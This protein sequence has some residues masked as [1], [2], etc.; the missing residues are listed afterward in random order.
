[1]RT[2]ASP[3]ST[4][5]SLATGAGLV[6]AAAGVGALAA[7][8][9][10][11]VPVGLVGAAVGGAGLVLLL[12]RPRWAVWATLVLAFL[13]MGLK[14]YVDAPFG[15]GVDAL[16]V[17]GWVGVLLRARGRPD[18][19]ALTNGLTL[20]A[21]LWM[22]Y[23]AFEIANPEARSVVAWAYA[24]R[25][26][27]L[28]FLLAVPLAFW[29]L[30]RRRDLDV[31]LALWL[32]L[33]V[34]G[35]LT[36]L[37]QKFVGLDPFEQRWLDAGAHV[38]HVLFGRLR[39]FSFYTDAG[40]CG[41]AQAHGAVVAAILAVGPG[42]SRRRRLVLGVV[43]ALGFFGMFIAGTRGALAVPFAGFGAYLVLSKNWRALVLG[44][45]ALAVVFGVLRFTFV[46]NDVYE[47]RRM[48]MALVRG[49]ETPSMQV[50]LDNQRRLAH[51]LEA[52]PF[53]GGIGTVGTWGE[54]FSPGTFLAEFPPDS[55]YVRI[56]AET[57]IVGLWLH[58][59]VLG[60]ITVEGARRAWRVHDPPLRQRLLALHAGMVGI[61][62]ASYGNQVLGQMP[63]GLVLY[64]SMAFLFMGPS[65]E[66]GH[67]GN[68]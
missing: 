35:A 56:W 16:L 27:S 48:R 11:A 66:A 51:Y 54:R 45:L 22:A 14:R 9:G 60:F 6:L 23:V 28:Y 50:R 65:M 26:V 49:A 39:I 17:V 2:L 44:A 46:G 32:G 7:R 10:L 47:I 59:L 40:Q 37:R 36:G 33:T 29:C 43:A 58:L 55:W 3:V 63:T 21:A 68:E 38:Q 53:G 8:G 15:V 41:A 4:G 5:R 42:V 61:L 20:A 13:G 64:L 57:G 67:D 30:G 34:L 52:R 19:R 12:G 1:M 62:L 25:G 31:F 24:M 18:G